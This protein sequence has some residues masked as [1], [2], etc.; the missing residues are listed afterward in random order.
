MAYDTS[1][2]SPLSRY[3]SEDFEVGKNPIE[4]TDTMNLDLVGV[5]GNEILARVL[6]PF[7]R[8]SVRGFD[9]NRDLYVRVKEEAEGDGSKKA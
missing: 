9:T 6:H 1:R 8:I 3:S 4:V 7:F 5:K 2:G